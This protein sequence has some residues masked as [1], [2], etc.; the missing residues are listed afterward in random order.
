MSRKRSAED[1]YI[2]RRCLCSCNPRTLKHEGG[3]Q[4]M[5]A[6]D[7]PPL[8]VLRMDY[9]TEVAEEMAALRDRWGPAAEERRR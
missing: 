7:K 2:C 3:G 4:G 1:D 9:E 5:K 8:P 6:C